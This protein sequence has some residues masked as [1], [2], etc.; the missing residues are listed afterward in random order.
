MP[1]L[2]FKIKIIT[3]ILAFIFILN[4]FLPFS[5]ALGKCALDEGGK[6]FSSKDYINE[7]NIFISKLPKLS[8]DELS[9]GEF[10]VKDMGNQFSISY[11]INGGEKFLQNI[12]SD[13]YTKNAL[14]DFRKKLREEGSITLG[15]PHN[16][17]D[18]LVELE[19]Q[20]KE[21]KVLFYNIVP[22][23]IGGL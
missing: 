21:Y 13:D 16:V 11:S 8:N 6:D 12:P 9:Q 7:I 22:I 14:E 19:K 10:R 20:L 15:H 23:K 2:N 4:F 5:I 3:A 1:N 18:N 17:I